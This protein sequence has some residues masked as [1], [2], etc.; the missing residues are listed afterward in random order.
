MGNKFLNIVCRQDKLVILLKSQ[1]ST[2]TNLEIPYP[3]FTGKAAGSED[4]V[5]RRVERDAPRC[6]RMSVECVQTLSSPYVRYTDWMIAVRWC[7]LSPA[8]N[9]RGWSKKIYKY[10]RAFAVEVLPFKEYC[11][12]M[13]GSSDNQRTHLNW[14]SS[15]ELTVF[16]L[17]TRM[18]ENIKFTFHINKV[19]IGAQHTCAWC[20]HAD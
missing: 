8:E 18:A 5:I 9:A 2:N 13:T 20:K 6:S 11:R 19:L 14:R 10:V 17:I 15:V 1:K 12:R 3:H 16:G 7:D 4:I